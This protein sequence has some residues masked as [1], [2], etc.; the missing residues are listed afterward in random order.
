[1]AESKGTSLRELAYKAAYGDRTSGMNDLADTVMET[2]EKYAEPMAKAA[3][4]RQA[5]RQEKREDKKE[6]RDAGYSR[7]EARRAVNKGEFPEF[8]QDGNR[9]PDSLQTIGTPDDKDGDGIPDTIDAGY[10]PKGESIY[11]NP[12]ITRPPGM[13]MRSPIKNLAAGAFAAAYNPSG[14]NMNAQIDSIKKSIQAVS[15]QQKKVLIDKVVAELEDFVPEN[16]DTQGFAGFKNGSAAVQNFGLD[17]KKKLAEKKSEAIKLN[18]YSQEYKKVIGEIDAITKSS[19]MLVMEKTRLSNLK[20]EWG[21]SSDKADNLYSK[22]SSK[23]TMNYLNQVMSNTAGMTL[24]EQ[25]QA[26][27]TVAKVDNKGNF[28]Y[29]VSLD[30]SNPVLQTETITIQDLNKNLYQKVDVSNEVKDYHQVLRKDIMDKVSFNKGGS[31]SFWSGIIA[32]EWETGMS[33]G[34]LLSFIH[35]RP[36]NMYSQTSFYDDFTSYFKGKQLEITA[37]GEPL[38][39]TKDAIDILFDPDTR[40]WDAETQDGKTVRE[41][42]RE[43]LINYYSRKSEQ[44]YYYT[45]KKQDP[46]SNTIGTAISQVNREFSN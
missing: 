12:Y 37:D 38:V 28:V 7:G 24:N 6:F 8:D 16:V 18:P 25:G 33:D 4:E 36:Y 29:E 30:G 42:I 10:D 43:E 32:P 45:S 15:A 34:D 46:T 5:A 19:K 3:A 44:Y 2:Y 41:Y 35:D 21:T 13:T 31:K 23:K 9:I 39:M 40:D 20:K 1:M 11:D 27:F 17:L 14:K 26:Q 22:G